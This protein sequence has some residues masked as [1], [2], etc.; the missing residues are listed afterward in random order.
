LFLHGTDDTL[1]PLSNGR[2][3]FDAAAEPKQ[4]I[5]TPGGHN[6]AGFT[7]SPEFTDRLGAFIDDVLSPK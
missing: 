4:F 6:E 1:I 5:E 7:Y 3:L 2:K